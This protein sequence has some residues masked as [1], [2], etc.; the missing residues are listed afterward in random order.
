MIWRREP[1]VS[2]LVEVGEPVGSR[3]VACI[4]SSHADFE[5]QENRFGTGG[6]EGN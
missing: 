3:I 1:L 4:R 6:A 5:I 2:M